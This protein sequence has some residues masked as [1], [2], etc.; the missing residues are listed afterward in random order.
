MNTV[1]FFWFLTG[2][3][4]L[5]ILIGLPVLWS[6]GYFLAFVLLATFVI[7]L[8]LCRHCPEWRKPGMFLRCVHYGIPKVYPPSDQPLSALQK[9]CVFAGFVVIYGAGAV[10][11]LLA[12][13]Y[14]L[15]L[16]VAYNSV[17]WFM[18]MQRTIC[19]S[20]ANSNCPA[21]RGCV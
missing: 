14:A 9:F 13:Q 2:T 7:P 4:V 20:C 17:V 11:L 6:A 21:N 1:V 10:L 3:I 18:V 8:Y 15:S 19:R 5:P 16:C 12:K